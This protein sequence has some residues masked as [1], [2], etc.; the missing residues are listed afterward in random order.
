[1]TRGI[2]QRWIKIFDAKMAGR[3]TLLL[4]DNAPS[5]NITNLNLQNTTIFFLPPNTTSRM[6]PMDAGII[7]SFKCHYR[8]YFVK[9]L[10]HQYES[11]AEDKKMDI[12]S[13][14]RFVVR[15]W[16]EVAKGTISNCFRHTEIL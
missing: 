9:W 1:M 4:L 6:Q 12:L 8:S 7:M 3:Q 14:I 5:H 15:A 13:A 16:D 11:G 2:F 10:L